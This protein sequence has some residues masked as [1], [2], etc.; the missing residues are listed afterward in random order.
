MVEGIIMTRRPDT[1][2][3]AVK[4]PRPTA[5]EKKHTNELLDE[6]LEETFPAS[7]T[8]A[9]IEP[10]PGSPPPVKNKR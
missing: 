6:A 10:T 1:Q 4:K 5:Q 2:P 9:M 7:D 8:P 3:S